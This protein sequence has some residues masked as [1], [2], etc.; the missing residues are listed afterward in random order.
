MTVSEPPAGW[1]TGPLLANSM[2]AKPL[3]GPDREDDKATGDMP[4]IR[5]EPVSG[6]EPAP[7][8]GEQNPEADGAGTGPAERAEI[9]LSERLAALGRMAAAGAARSGPGGFSPELVRDAEELLTRAGERLRL[10]S[11]HTVVVLAG[12]TGSGKSSLF[13]RLAGADFSPSGVTRPMTRYQH[14][15]V[16][17]PDGA[18]PLLD[19]L[20]VPTRYR[21]SRSSALDEG[22]RSLSG[23]ILLDLPDHDSVLAGATGQVH[24]LIKLADLMIWV[25]DPQK[26]ADAAVHNRYLL[27]MAGHS[28]VIAVVLNQADLLTGEQAEDCAA[29]L[30]RL[31]DSEGLTDAPVLLT[32]AATGAGL[33][34]LRLLLT[35]TVTARRAAAER[36]GA[37]VDAVAA[38]FL[39]YAGAEP[40]Q[41][42]AAELG[43]ALASAAGVA[44]VG[45]ALQSARELRAVDYV[46]WPVGWL[47]GR[48]T[49]RDPLRKLR[50][51]NLWE[52][53]RGAAA[54]PA[55]AQQADIDKALTVLAD[56]VGAGLPD[57]WPATV[58]QAARSQAAEIPGALGTAI[59][60]TLPEEN[61]VARWWRAVAGWQGLLLGCTVTAAVWLGLLL[62]FGV[63][64]ASRQVPALFTQA[65]LLP[66]V[67]ALIVGFLLLGWLTGAGCMS[68]V[69]RSAARERT[70]TEAAIR[71]SVAQVAQRMVL[72]PVERE[73]ADYARFRENL[74]IALNIR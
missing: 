52:E 15:C 46:G 17:G 47:F 43:D 27:P 64:H 45:R 74:D 41:A 28:G 69:I 20:G 25:L 34:D 49:G 16:W 68:L 31:L 44:G 39:P 61:R 57:P 29:D 48:I 10:S 22:E 38:R 62:A 73:L 14:A 51:G 59:A 63:F 56:Q 70:E 21:Y 23:L 18:G 30:R 37:D 26:Y 5:D 2:L 66:W 19:W 65:W 32:S 60:Q 40:P 58:R 53:L 72:G 67:G 24:Q 13:N 33:D 50:L 42:P 71:A 4:V 11:D 36:I 1:L 6:D 8:A 55:A 35:E 12:G 9:T 7:P 3:A 54:G